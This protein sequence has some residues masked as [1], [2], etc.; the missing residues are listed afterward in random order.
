MGPIAIGFMF[1]W[2]EVPVVP[3]PQLLE[4][5]KARVHEGTVIFLAAEIP[6]LSHRPIVFSRGTFKLYADPAARF[7]LVKSK[8]ENFVFF[9]LARRKKR[10]GNGST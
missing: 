1:T 10:K 7:T 6:L 2:S 3:A 8:K 5:H 9:F 4:V